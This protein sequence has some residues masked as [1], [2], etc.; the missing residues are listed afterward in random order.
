MKTGL[1]FTAR[2]GELPAETFDVV[3][4]HLHEGL[5]EL[6]ELSITLVSSEADI[7]VQSQLLK[8]A[9][10]TVFSYGTEQRTVNGVVASLMQGDTG[11]R[12]TY[13]TVIIRPHL[14]TLTLGRDSRIFHL[15]TVP[16]IL[17]E[18]L[19]EHSV[20]AEKQ[21]VTSHPRREYTT[22][23]RESYYEFF[24]RLAAEEGISYWF[25]GKELYYSDT[26]LTMKND[27]EAI[28]N[29]H[30][31]S[32]SQGNII[33]KLSFGAT[34]QPGSIEHKD[35]TYHSPRLPLSHRKD[36]SHE[37]WPQYEVFESYGRYQNDRDSERFAQYRLDSIRADS[38]QG[39]AQSNC[40]KLA[41]GKIFTLTEH[42]NPKMNDRWQVVTAVHHGKQPAALEEE[43]DYGGTTLT[44]SLTFIP[45]KQDWRPPYKYKPLADGDE[46]GVIVGPANEEIY[47]NADGAVRVHFHWNRYD[48]ADDRASC[49]IRVT[50]GWNGS[51][52]GFMA[53]PRIGQ[54]VIVSYLNGDIDRPV[55]TGCNYNALNRPPL[56][57]PKEKTRTTFRTKTHKGEGFN[58][59]RFED[60]AGREEIFIHGQKD[61]L[62]HILN[63]RVTEVGHDHSEVI[64]NNQT[65]HI[66]QNQSVK[67][68]AERI[69]ETKGTQHHTVDGEQRSHIKGQYSL[70][71]EGD[72]HQKTAQSHHIES[73]GAIH[74]KSGQ[75]VIIDAGAD[76]TINAGGSFITIN[77]SGITLSGPSIN[78]N[79]SGS[80][81]RAMGFAGNMPV[82]P[83]SLALQPE[84][85]NTLVEQEPPKGITLYLESTDGYPIPYTS[86]I[87][88]F[89]T[90]ETRQGMLDKDGKVFLP[91]VPPDTDYVYDYPDHDDILAKANAQR[92]QKAI[93]TN[94]AEAIVGLLG[95][96]STIMQA[97]AYAYYDI[98]NQNMIAAIDQQLSPYHEDRPVIDY[99]LTKAGFETKRSLSIFKSD[100]GSAS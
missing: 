57:L 78:L 29:P 48:E 14:W 85:I 7:D 84:K 40:F 10:L 44:N 69:I 60:E 24:S 39:T 9:S 70:T 99:L 80:A 79:S 45:G 51:G 95:Y 23:K 73:G 98:F 71:V 55:I 38:Q 91:D 74:V 8:R 64:G 89:A 35:Y 93:K 11:F 97:T 1:Y 65:L 54:E 53:I 25:E 87:V 90:G 36:V 49:W 77:A 58:E 92:M 94:D 26:H 20:R 76:V 66:K 30:P 31:Q 50:Q 15:S 88:R 5:S 22:M 56:D 67:V 13:Y 17:D 61:M 100:A 46:I 72:V 96:S 75:K 3:E 16:E 12:R 32:A 34:M 81:E 62:T 83:A 68:D 59:L 19:K 6:F 2:I 27:V 18:I 4:F 21:F 42:P 82:L 28:Y 52:Y 47:T 86:Y 37:I 43:S 63:D 41:P 33:H